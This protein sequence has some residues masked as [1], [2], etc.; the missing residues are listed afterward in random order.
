MP[1]GPL[2]VLVCATVCLDLNIGLVRAFKSTLGVRTVRS[3]EAIFRDDLPGV[4]LAV[5]RIGSAH[6]ITCRLDLQFA[7]IIDDGMYTI[8]ADPRNRIF[9]LLTVP[10]R[11]PWY[12]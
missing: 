12:I 1:P 10:S 2:R 5:R 11:H 8:A 4:S 3:T 7:A 6:F 9:N